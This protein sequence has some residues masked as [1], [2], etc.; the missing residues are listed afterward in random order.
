MLQSWKWPTLILAFV[1]T[2]CVPAAEEK[3]T[4][5]DAPTLAAVPRFVAPQPAGNGTQPQPASV[6]V[7]DLSIDQSA[8]PGD[9]FAGLASE[10]VS[11]DGAQA[12][13][14]TVG[15]GETDLVVIAPAL[16]DGPGSCGQIALDG[17][18]LAR[19]ALLQNIH[20][21]FVFPADAQDSVGVMKLA[22]AGTDLAPAGVVNL[23]G[24]AGEDGIGVWDADGPAERSLVMD[25]LIQA[26]DSEGVAAGFAARPAGAPTHHRDFQAAG[27]AAVGLTLPGQTIV[28]AS[29][30]SNDSQGAQLLARAVSVFDAFVGRTARP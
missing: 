29:G 12:V 23:G 30:G 22:M 9:P 2:A 8:L 7:P 1:A 25:A 27:I 28:P 3:A 5:D 17:Y 24:C 20:A 10:V 6:V 26:G 11:A 16:P 4:D 21:R 19:Q 15:S 18:N 13:V 14:L